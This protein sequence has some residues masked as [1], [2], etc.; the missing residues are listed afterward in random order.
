MQEG[1]SAHEAFSALDGAQ[2]GGGESSICLRMRMLVG[3][4]AAT[5]IGMLHERQ[6]DFGYISSAEL[7][8]AHRM[9]GCYLAAKGALSDGKCSYSTGMLHALT[10]TGKEGHPL[11]A[12]LANLVLAVN[13]VVLGYDS[14][15]KSSFMEGFEVLS[16][17]RLL[18]PLAMEYRGLMGLP[19][20][21]L[22]N[23]EE[24]TLRKIRAHAVR[25]AYLGQLSNGMVGELPSSVLLSPRESSLVQLA[26]LGKTNKEIAAFVGLST[27]T[28]KYHLSNSYAKLNIDGRTGL[29]EG[30][31]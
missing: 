31:V 11:L 1:A 14:I 22:R 28:V 25:C 7:P 15:A 21:C 30:L 4:F 6:D 8:Y 12:A 19:W 2:A 13:C 17:D 27:H 20:A 18:A 9:L 23:G 5:E 26:S 10:V 16:A 3:D 24:A 29:A